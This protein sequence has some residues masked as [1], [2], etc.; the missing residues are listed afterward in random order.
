MGRPKKNKD[1]ND[2]TGSPEAPLA[3]PTPELE[4][5]SPRFQF[6]DN[7]AYLAESER[8]GAPV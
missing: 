1:G 7:D 2:P 3:E 8:P 5:E 4:E 6:F